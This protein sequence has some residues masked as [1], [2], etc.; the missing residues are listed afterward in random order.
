MIN[1]P[2]EFLD[3]DELEDEEELFQ[4]ERRLFSCR[5]DKS[6]RQSNFYNG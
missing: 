4:E 1:I 3:K 2:K 5:F 6:A